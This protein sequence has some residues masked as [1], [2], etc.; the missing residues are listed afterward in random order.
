MVIIN[1]DSF[2]WV[3]PGVI[4]NASHLLHHFDTWCVV[5][6]QHLVLVYDKGTGPRNANSL[7]GNMNRSIAER[8][9]ERYRPIGAV[10]IELVPHVF[11]PDSPGRY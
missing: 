7:Q 11:L 6:D 4:P 8:F 10:G 1:P 5:N 2:T 3:D 9:L